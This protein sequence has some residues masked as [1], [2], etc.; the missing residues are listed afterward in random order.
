MGSTGMNWF[1][2]FAIR[3][4]T[5]SHT[6]FVQQSWKCLLQMSAH[7]SAHTSMHI[8]TRIITH[9]YTSL[10][11]STHKY[12]HKYTSIQMNTHPHTHTHPYTFVLFGVHVY[13]L[14][15]ACAWRTW[16]FIG[17]HQYT[18]L[19]TSVRI[20]THTTDRRFWLINSQNDSSEISG[21]EKQRM[22]E[23]YP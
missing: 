20:L 2:S 7:T 8:S 6:V 18:H 21:A 13:A 9:Q 19:C 4:C 11:I 5:V 3:F 16:I 23:F 1:C 15:T 10:H 14:F 22:Y 12:T 17:T